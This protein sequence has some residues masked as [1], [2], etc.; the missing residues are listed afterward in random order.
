MQHVWHLVLQPLTTPKT[1]VTQ[2]TG[3]IKKLNK[4]E[5]LLTL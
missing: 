3:C 4:S 5:I 1:Y 2:F